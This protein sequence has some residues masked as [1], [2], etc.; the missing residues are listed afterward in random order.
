MKMQLWRPVFYVPVSL[1]LYMMLLD[2]SAVGL[3][4]VPE[5]DLRS[6]FCR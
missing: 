3:V 5:K 6:L 1:C 4:E 2:A